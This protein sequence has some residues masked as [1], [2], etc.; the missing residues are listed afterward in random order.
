MKTILTAEPM[1]PPRVRFS[2]TPKQNDVLRFVLAEVRKHGQVPG[3]VDVAKHFG[4][5]P[6]NGS[7]FLIVLVEKG[8]L[9]RLRGRRGLGVAPGV[10][11]PE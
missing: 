1:P 4:V 2:L 7:R 11:A 10:R 6:T 3:P 9:I 8:W 5:H